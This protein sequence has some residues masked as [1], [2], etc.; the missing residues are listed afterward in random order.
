NQCHHL[1][2]NSNVIN[3][4]ITSTATTNAG[5]V[6]SGSATAPTTAGNNLQYLTFTNNQVIGGYYGFILMGNAGQLDNYGHYIANNTF[7]DFYGYGVYLT[8]ADTTVV[9]GNDIHRSGRSTVLATSYITYLATSRN[10]KLRKNRIHDVGG[11]T[12]SYPIYLTNCVN[13]A[14][15]ETEISNNLIYNLGVTGSM[16]G[17][18]SVTTAISNVNIYHNTIQHN[19]VSGTG[20]IRGIFLSVAITN[21]N[22]KNNIIAITGAGTGVKTGIYITTTSASFVSNNN[23]IYVN[24]SA[25]NNVGYWTAARV[26][27]TDWSNASGQDILSKDLDPQFTSTAT[28]NFKPLAAGINNIGAPVGIST[29]ILGLLRSTATPDAGA[30]ETLVPSNNNAGVTAFTGPK[31]FCGGN[32]DVKVRVRNNG[33]NIISYV[34][35]QWMLDGVPQT[36]VSWVYPMDTLGGTTYPNDTVI[37]LGNVF[38]GGK[39]KALRAWTEYPNSVAD[40]VNTDDTIAVKITPTLN[41]IYTIGG[42]NP[43]YA[44]ITEAV[45]ALTT[46]G[47]CAPVTFNVLANSPVL[48]TTLT[49]GNIAG[50]S[51]VNTITFNGNL[52]SISSTA[53]P[54]IDFNGASY[55]RMDSFNITGSGTAYL[56]IGVHIWGQ[57]HH[58]TLDHNRI[59]VST[60]ETGT[61]S[62]AAIAISGSITAP[63]TA[64]NNARYLT[65]RDNILTGGYYSMTATGNTGSLDNY[66]H[67]IANNTCKDFYLYGIYLANADTVTVLNNDINRA[68]R[69]VVS[70]FYGIYTATSRNIHIQK[71]R[72]HD[73]G[74]DSYTAYPVYISNS[75]NTAGY[76]TEISNNMIY[77][78]GTTGVMYGIYGLT[79]AITGVNIYHNTIQYTVPASSTS[80]IRGIFL[81]VAVTNVN[82]KNNIID[83]TGGGTGVKTGIYVTTPSSGFISN[84]NLVHVSTSAGTDNFG[85]WGA[86]NLS[87]YDWEQASG[88]DV[89]SQ[90]LNA[91]F[92]NLA[93]GNLKPLSAAIDNMGVPVGVTTDITGLA[94]NL[95]APDVG[96]YEFSTASVCSGTPFAGNAVSGTTYACSGKLF[97][98]SLANDSIA[99]GLKYQWQ[100]A[101]AQSGPYLPLTNDTL[102]NMK[103]T[104]TATNW[105]RCVVT[106]TNSGLSQN[107]AAVRIRTTTTTL[108]GSYTLNKALPASSVNYTSFTDL[109]DELN[110]NGVSG[111]VT[112]NVTPNTGPYD[113][114]FMFDSIPGVSP[115]NTITING[116]GNRVTSG[117]SPIV[118]FNRSSYIIIDS[119]NIVADSG[120]TGFGIHMG[121]ASHHL[122][123][124]RNVVNVGLTATAA[125]C[126]GIVSSGSISSATTAGNNARYL[127]ITNNVVIGGY[128]STTLM[129]NTGYLDNYG[130]TIANNTFRDFYLYGLYMANTDSTLVLNNDINRMTRSTL[131]TFYG[132]YGSSVRNVKYRNN[133]IHDAGSGTYTAY[134]VYITGSANTSGYE[135]EFINNATYNISTTGSVYGYYLLGTRDRM[136]F[137]HNTVDINLVSSTGTIRG[138]YMTTAPD[139]HEFKNNIISISGTGTGEKHVIYAG[140]SSTTITSDRNILYVDTTI[141]TNFIGYLGANQKTLPNWRT[142]AGVDLNSI[143]NNPVF[144]NSAAGDVRPLSANC[145]NLGTNVGV[146]TDITGAARS[147]ST[148]DAGAFEFTGINGDLALTQ[149]RLVRSGICYSNADT[150]FITVKNMIGAMADFSINPITIYWN[151]TGPV[152]SNGSITVSSGTLVSGSSAAYYSN[153][154][155]RSVPGNYMVSAYLQANA[156]NMSLSNDTLYQNQVFTVS[157]ILSVGTRTFNVNSPTDSVAIQAL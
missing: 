26:S 122:T 62:N 130:H 56:G 22:V 106:C 8:N 4:G 43:D 52:S 105:Y 120:F 82:F 29:D 27:L 145:D 65:I 116:N 70:T 109:V 118:R 135:T 138:L 155:N 60:T 117:I 48:A 59:T 108:N 132:L 53:T 131:S 75:V 76:E 104:Q 151:V 136:K 114:N 127:T 19:V 67:Y 101:A 111:A 87:R 71:N 20:I 139:N 55:I 89:S 73:A 33:G 97:N 69:A 119:L 11:T 113:G 21:V 74:A 100:K 81:S 28:G 146:S 150:V 13:A 42:T 123:L 90:E 45:A 92:T 46:L 41:G 47:V 36:P 58:I 96:A 86:V 84:H 110:C 152:N 39:A 99:L 37:T 91:V 128:Y 115:V 79:T 154:V 80:A 126:A 129:G 25:S 54:I 12:A 148:P 66:G 153:T 83:I 68:T 93:T 124:I 85:Y 14:G 6:A 78:I 133:R 103:A 156:I 9:T 2:F 31:N 157:P 63:T 51:A 142:A 57:S 88:Q 144:A 77:N 121:G 49:F 16:Y 50:A 38:F 64:G 7:R 94:R 10:I 15:Y 107:S 5:F 44:T 140:A 32:Q 18:Y 112:I 3:A 147:S 95:S 30:Y 1:T 40:T 24:T 23:V 141:V 34:T 125:T 17:I 61:T 143:A 98:I 134:P 72:I 137:Y 149:G 102:K 35:I